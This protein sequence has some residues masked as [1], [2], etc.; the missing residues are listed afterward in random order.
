[1]AQAVS[2]TIAPAK[3]KALKAYIV[4]DLLTGRYRLVFAT[5]NTQARRKGANECFEC[6]LSEVSAC[7][8][9]WADAYAAVDSV[10]LRVLVEQCW[11]L[12]DDHTGDSI[13][14]CTIAEMGLTLD[15]L[16][17]DH[18]G[19]VF[20]CKAHAEAYEAECAERDRSTTTVDKTENGRDE[21]R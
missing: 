20:L 16:V 17:G 18:K 2:E 7:R 12:Y 1:M 19:P 3:A 6:L 15:D 4:E 10:P 8:S 9:P 5:N 14:E 11:T 13:D 21:A